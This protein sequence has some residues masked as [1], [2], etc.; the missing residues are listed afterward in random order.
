MSLESKMLAKQIENTNRVLTSLERITEIVER[1]QAEWEE[2]KTA[3]KRP[4]P[5]PRSP[6]REIDCEQPPKRLKKLRSFN[7]CAVCQLSAKDSDEWTMCLESGCDAVICPE[8]KFCAEHTP[9]QEDKEATDKPEKQE[10][11]SEADGCWAPGCD[12]QLHDEDYPAVCS[13]P[14][15]ANPICNQC[16]GDA[17]KAVYCVDHALAGDSSGNTLCAAPGCGDRLRVGR[18]SLCKGKL[19]TKWICHQCPPL[20][21]E[22]MPKKQDA[23]LHSKEDRCRGQKCSRRLD[24]GVP[25][26]CGEPS[27]SNPICSNCLDADPQGVY[28]MD[29][30]VLSSRSKHTWDVRNRCTNL[31]CGRLTTSGQRVLC[32]QNM[33]LGWICSDCDK[34]SHYCDAHRDA[35]EDAAV[36]SD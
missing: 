14:F 21:E 20:C 9:T 30:A 4:E 18:R 11:N 23:P 32:H 17:S 15:C 36:N 26:R 24:R 8:H 12:R 10:S 16:V 1:L 6:S 34:K 35:P 33:C 3:Q 7:E 31:E 5:E 2:F 28:C 27:C 13:E 19:C 25:G 22:H 29:H